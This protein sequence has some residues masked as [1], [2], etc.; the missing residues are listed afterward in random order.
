[1]L[2]SPLW[3]TELSTNH[4]MGHSPSGGQARRA[5][6]SLPQSTRSQGGWEALGPPCIEFISLLRD[7]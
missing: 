2:V 7:S 1:M 6:R 3:T 4:S 5:P